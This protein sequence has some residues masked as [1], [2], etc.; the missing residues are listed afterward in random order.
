MLTDAIAEQALAALRMDNPKEA[1][2]KLEELI[3]QAPDRI[4]LRHAFAVTLVRMGEAKAAKLVASQGIQMA[5]EQKNDTAATLLSPLYLV[6]ANACEELY[7]PLEAEKSYQKILEHE[8]ENPYARQR[9]AYLLFAMG[10]LDQGLDQLAKYLEHGTDEVDS[11]KAHEGLRD[12]IERFMREDI[13]PKN[14]LQAHRESYVEE[15]NKLTEDLEAK[16]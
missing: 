14:F 5:Y 15:F 6:L 16:A 1:K 2:E 9:Y 13:H 8:E 10:E 12:H 7:Q 4:D 11:L 3:A